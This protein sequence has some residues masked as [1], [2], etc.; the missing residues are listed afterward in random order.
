MFIKF[1]SMDE[2]GR[3]AQVAIQRDAILAII[4]RP[5]DPDI[6]LIR[7]TM[8]DNL[9]SINEPFSQCFQKLERDLAEEGRESEK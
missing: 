8:N 9:M 5:S 6:T 1:I 2:N 3:E 4:E 7:T